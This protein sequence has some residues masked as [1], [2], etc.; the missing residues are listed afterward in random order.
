MIYITGDTHGRFD[1]VFDFCHRHETTQDDILII[2]GDAGINYWGDIRDSVLKNRLSELPI[3][4]F[5]IHGNHEKR[6]QS[7]PDYEPDVFCGG[8]VFHE[9]AYKNI[10]FG[11]DGQVYDFGGENC[12]VIGGAYSVDKPYRIARGMQ[13]FEDEQPDA[14]VKLRVEDRIGD[15][16][17]DVI[18]SHTCPYRYLPTE[19]FLP[20]IDQSTVD[21][22]TEKW[23]GEIEEKCDYRR[24]Y[25]GHFH[26]D[27]H[28]DAV[29]FMSMDICALNEGGSYEH[30]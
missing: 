25:C 22:S 23:L 2:L 3:T 13:W 27:K 8:V 11:V 4:L 18:L 24:W 12:L 28:I 14:K 5:C 15:T 9:R 21:N 10:L 7:I 30:E 29:R 17:V 16:R 1:R 19:A 26:I 20:M 6:P